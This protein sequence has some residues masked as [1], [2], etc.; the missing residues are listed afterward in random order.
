MDFKGVSERLGGGSKDDSLPD[1][2]NA[3][4]DWQVGDSDVDLHVLLVLEQLPV[5]LTGYVLGRLVQDLQHCAGLIRQPNG[6]VGHCIGQVKEADVQSLP[7]ACMEARLCSSGMNIP[8]LISWRLLMC[9][10]AC[11]LN[12]SAVFHNHPFNQSCGKR[13]TL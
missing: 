5:L 9:D 1:V 7:V 2:A 11:R 3:V 13:H 10:C 8:L 6:G 12:L 4:C